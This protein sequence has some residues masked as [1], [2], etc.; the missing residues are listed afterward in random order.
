[1]AGS[2]LRWMPAAV[3]VA[4]GIHIDLCLLH[5]QVTLLLGARQGSRGAIK[6]LVEPAHER[7]RFL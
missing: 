1:M 2:I 5:E 3:H 7:R 4:L 6:Q